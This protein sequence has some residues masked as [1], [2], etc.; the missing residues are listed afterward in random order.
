MKRVFFLSYRQQ[1]L[2]RSTTPTCDFFFPAQHH[3][4]SK[5]P[6]N[7]VPFAESEDSS[8]RQA[9]DDLSRGAQ[10]STV[11]C[12]PHDVALRPRTVPSVELYRNLLNGIGSGFLRTKNA[13]SSCWYWLVGDFGLDIFG[14]LQT[15]LWHTQRFGCW[16]AL[17]DTVEVTLARAWNCL[18]KTRVTSTAD[19][20]TLGRA[21]N[22]I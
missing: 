20:P 2:S 13:S 19:D 9:I 3:V 17:D 1:Q 15:T 12:L 8:Q 16:P 6:L 11:Q 14:P 22:F 4:S 5:I 10:R 21:R 7:H 18:E